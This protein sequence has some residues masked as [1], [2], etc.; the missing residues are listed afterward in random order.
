MLII[1][2]EN[3]ADGAKREISFLEGKEMA[4]ILVL[5]ASAKDGENVEE[6]FRSIIR[7]FMSQ[8]INNERRSKW[9][10]KKK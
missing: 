1:L 6:T 5:E 4:Q 3:K 2:V 7:Q 9:S 8:S 10:P